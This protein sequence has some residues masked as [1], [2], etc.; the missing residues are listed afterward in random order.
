MGSNLHGSSPLLFIC[1]SRFWIRQ[2][3]ENKIEL[4]TNN[5]AP[6]V[7]F[8]RSRIE[9]LEDTKTP[10]SLRVANSHI[11]A[12]AK[13]AAAIHPALLVLGFSNYLPLRRSVSDAHA[14][15]FL[16]STGENAGHNVSVK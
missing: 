3:A 8:P 13:R 10:R 6:M 12:R 14:T 15:A 4:Q 16:N 5:P 9:Y 11:L 2:R 7:P 1:L